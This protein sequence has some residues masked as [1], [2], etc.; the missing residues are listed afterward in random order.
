M[1]SFRGYRPDRK[2]EILAKS[3]KAVKDLKRR[4]LMEKR[5]NYKIRDPKENPLD[6]R[7]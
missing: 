1:P 2:E 3:R 5:K 7:I 4:K 6:N